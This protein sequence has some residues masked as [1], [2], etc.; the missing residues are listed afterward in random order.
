MTNLDAEIRFLRR[1]RNV[2]IAIG[3]VGAAVL[4]LGLLLH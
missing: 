2:S 4:L 3:F 1:L